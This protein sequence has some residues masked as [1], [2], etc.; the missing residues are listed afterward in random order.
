MKT[1]IEFLNK[2]KNF[3][4]DRI[5]FDS[6]EDAVTWGRENIENFNLDM[7]HYKF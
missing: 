7:I 2:D 6:Y 5:E 3:Q 4:P 1:Y